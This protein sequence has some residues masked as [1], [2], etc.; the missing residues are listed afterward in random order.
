MKLRPATVPRSEILRR[1]REKGLASSESEAK[2]ALAYMLKRGLLRPNKKG[3]DRGTRSVYPMNSLEVIDEIGRSRRNHL[4][5][6]IVDERVRQ[7]QTGALPAWLVAVVQDSLIVQWLNSPPDS[8][9]GQRFRETALWG[10]RGGTLPWPDKEWNYICSHVCVDEDREFL[11][12]S[13]VLGAALEPEANNRESYFESTDAAFHEEMTGCLRR[14]LRGEVEPDQPGPLIVLP[15]TASQ[16]GG[17]H[18]TFRDYMRHRLG[19]VV[20][21]AAA[22]EER[23]NLGELWPQLLRRRFAVCDHCGRFDLRLDRRSR[24][25]CG[26]RCRIEF[27]NER[28]RVRSDEGRRQHDLAVHHDLRGPT[29]AGVQPRFPAPDVIRQVVRLATSLPARIDAQGGALIGMLALLL[30]LAQRGH[31]REPGEAR[32]VPAA[33]SASYFKSLPGWTSNPGRP[34]YYPVPLAALEEAGLLV[35]GAPSMRSAASESRDIAAEEPAKRRLGRLVIGVFP[36]T[37]QGPDLYALAVWEVGERR[38]EKMRIAG[39]LASIVP[40]DVPLD[41]REPPGV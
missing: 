21:E 11:R 24:R 35:Q 25:F 28:R 37:A 14:V 10:G 40:D 18:A 3:V 17:T 2:R 23:P 7:I 39:K 41:D 22:V 1:I 6:R 20:R 8:A 33:L 19:E 34:T 30:D 36:T 12:G 9:D 13:R 32:G 4:P 15:T 38:L 26:D 27:H 5:W 29:P 16:H 31:V